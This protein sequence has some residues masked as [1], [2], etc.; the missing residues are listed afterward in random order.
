M[1][2]FDYFKVYLISVP[3][4]FAIDMVWLT[5]IAKNFYRSQLGDLL[6]KD[7]NWLAAIV[8][9]LLFLVGL[10]I[11]AVAPALEKN[12]WTHALIFSALFGFFTYMTYDLTNLATT[13]NW[14]LTL[15]FVDIAW[16]TFLAASV[17][18]VTFLIS[19]YFKI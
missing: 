9:Y 3:V 16:G 8:F 10:I 4:F 14:P 7:I 12:S 5:L 13:R 19:Q 6:T 2:T 11:F 15:T 17:A 18:T 1:S